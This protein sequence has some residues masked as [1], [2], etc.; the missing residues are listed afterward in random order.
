M[1][2]WYGLKY[3]LCYC[4]PVQHNCQNIHVQ[5]DVSNTVNQLRKKEK[6]NLVLEQKMHYLLESTW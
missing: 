4:K 5:F 3:F 1:Y 6:N 2:L